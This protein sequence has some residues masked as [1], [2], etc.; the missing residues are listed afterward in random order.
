[1]YPLF[2]GKGV[3]FRWNHLRAKGVQKEDEIF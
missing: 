1:M 3:P 2:V